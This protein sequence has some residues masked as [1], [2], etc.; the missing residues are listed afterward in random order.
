MGRPIDEKKLQHTLATYFECGQNICATARRLGCFRQAVQRRL[1]QAEALYGVPLESLANGRVNELEREVFPLPPE[2]GVNRY[3]LT[4]AQNNTHPHL[5]WKS[6]LAYADFLDIQPLSTCRL[7][8][9]TFSY[10][11]GRYG[12][13][14]VKRGKEKGLSAEWYSPELLPYVYDRRA[15]LA[16]GLVW[17]GEMNIIPTAKNPLTGME[18][19]NGRD[20]NIIPHNKQFLMSIPSMPGEAA[21][22]N[23]STGTIT[24]RNY[25]QRRAGIVAEQSHM[26]GALIV[27]VNHAGDWWVRQLQ[28]V[29][30]DEKAIIYDIGEDKAT[31]IQN[32]VV[33]FGVDA[34]DSIV[35]GDIHVA[36]MSQEIREAHW[37][38]RGLVD[39][40]HPKRQFMHDVFSMYARGHH[41]LKDFHANYRKFI[42][43]RDRVEQEVLDA[44]D[45]LRYSNREWCQSIVVHSNHDRHLDRWLNEADPKKDIVN[46]R[47]FYH[48]QGL[49]L[50][51][52][53]GRQG[54]VL[55]AALQDAGAP[56]DILFLHDDESYLICEHMRGIE[57]GLHGDRGPNGARG[58]TRGLA[59]L[60]RR[61]NKG[62]SHSAE[63]YFGVYSTGA[64]SLDFSY[65][66]GP[67]S[68]SI[69]HIVTFENGARQ[70]ITYWKGKARA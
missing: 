10:T 16:P 14:S 6:L 5:G 28:I 64:C 63:I 7:I 56:D 4:S 9:G 18:D 30:N 13:H 23:Y 50:R 52:I 41:E 24:L 42:E 35:W 46:A 25:V 60:A 62:H 51:G 34:V 44:A 70:V 17:C 69:S 40:L 33:E 58:G 8:V 22:I 32:G 36:E 59:R 12:R 26:Y 57:C 15:Q 67:S 47:Y 38:P 39:T 65:T 48:L 49:K 68:H 43:R 27:E 31:R 21:K 2:G 3:I 53:E 29:G 54:S 45:F 20:S 55:P 61:V 11:I 1:K 66:H 37:A 19:Y